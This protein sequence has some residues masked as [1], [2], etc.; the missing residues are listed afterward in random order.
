LADAPNALDTVELG[1]I[2]GNDYLPGI[3][4]QFRLEP[5][6]L[7]DA[8][9]EAWPVWTSKEVETISGDY[10]Y[11]D[12]RPGATIDNKVVDASAAEWTVANTSVEEPSWP[13]DEGWCDGAVGSEP[14]NKYP[15]NL[16]FC[17]NV[18]FTGGVVHSDVSMTAE[19]R[20]TY[21]NSAAFRAGDG[22]DNLTLRRLRVEGGWDGLRLNSSNWHIDQCYVSN[23]R[24]DCM[25]NDT[26]TTGKVTN[27]LFEDVFVGPSFSPN[28]DPN[29][30][31]VLTCDGMLVGLQ[32]Y[33]YSTAGD[34]DP[35]FIIQTHGH[36]FK[37]ETGYSFDSV[38]LKNCVWI[39]RCAPFH[40][41][42]RWSQIINALDDAQSSNNTI[43]WA[44][45]DTIPQEIVDTPI[46]HASFTLDDYSGDPAAGEAAWDAIVAQWKINYDWEDATPP[47]SISP[48]AQ[49]VLDRMTA[50]TQA[51]IDAII[52]FV[53]SQVTSGNW[54]KID[55]FF[56]FALNASDYA[57]G[58]KAVTGSPNAMSRGSNGMTPDNSGSYFDTTLIPESL[59]HFSTATGDAG[60]Y[61]HSITYSGAANT[62][63]FGCTHSVSGQPL[64]IRQRGNDSND[65]EAH[66]NVGGNMLNARAQAGL[67]GHFGVQGRAGVLY[68]LFDGV[69]QAATRTI[70]SAARP[71][72]SIFVASANVG[73]SPDGT[74]RTATYTSFYIG[75]NLD[76]A[77]LISNMDTLHTALGV[78]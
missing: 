45:A 60:I 37:G 35:A 78:I 34:G 26:L 2:D 23:I 48:E 47:P 63:F 22:T 1:A 58:W 54:A 18:T 13:K 57:T 61:V 59:T 6:A 62:Q 40:S 8:E 39:F 17:E 56:C 19:W 21:C 10:G 24:D 55:E 31:Q 66:M 51:E 30:G 50:L 41:N 16:E 65:I 7:S 64:R 36:G 15:I 4:H 49:A 71:D 72:I 12:Y 14:I 42:N 67:S 74:T 9:I 20:V 69:Q 73:G 5:E 11:T 29:L 25:E 76:V 43:I 38:I 44:T 70:S 68:T 53:D 52:A 27:T 77:N 46:N 28:G 33:P 32:L 75:D 3:I